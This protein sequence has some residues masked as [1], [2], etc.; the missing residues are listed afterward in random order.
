MR[1]RSFAPDRPAPHAIDGHSLKFPGVSLS[2]HCGSFPGNCALFLC[3]SSRVHSIGHVTSAYVSSEFHFTERM[4]SLT[5]AHA[6]GADRPLPTA[7]FLL[8]ASLCF[9]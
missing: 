5:S 2:L 1:H 8:L 3:V 4:H 7:P 9:Q 6:L